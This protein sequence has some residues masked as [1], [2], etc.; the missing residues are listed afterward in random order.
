MG[1]VGKFIYSS[2]VV[3]NTLQPTWP[4]EYVIYTATIPSAFTGAGENFYLL[5]MGATGTSENNLTIVHR[6]CHLRQRLR[7][8]LRRDER[9]GSNASHHDSRR[10]LSLHNAD[11][12]CAG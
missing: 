2:M 12:R 11:G 5:L 10:L 4:V 3:V 7:L 1:L 6:C 9:Q 8:H